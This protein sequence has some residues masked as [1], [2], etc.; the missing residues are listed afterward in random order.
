MKKNVGKVDKVIRIIA[1]VG[2][3]A[4]AVMTQTTWAYLGVIPLLTAFVSFCPLYVPFGIKT[5][6][7][8]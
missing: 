4:Y 3:I 6:K 1:G 8:E 7:T 5:C 2:L